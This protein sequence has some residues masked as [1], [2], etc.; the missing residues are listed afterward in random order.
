[1]GRGAANIPNPLADFPAFCYIYELAVNPFFFFA[2]LSRN[3]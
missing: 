1:M 3:L 2:Y